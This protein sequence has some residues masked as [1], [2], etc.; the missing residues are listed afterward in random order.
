MNLKNLSIKYIYAKIR[1]LISIAYETPYFLLIIILN[2]FSS[3]LTILGIPLL[4]PALQFLQNKNLEEN[5]YID[6]LNIL[7]DF[8]KIDLNF[9]SII[10]TSSLLIFLGQVVLLL[11][12][13][14]SKK[15]KSIL[16][17]NIHFQ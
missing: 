3:F 9:F 7:F 8:F 5:K 16:K 15:Y 1:S 14:F 10:I 2:F 17:K 13:L 6:Y 4:V 11:I 12:E